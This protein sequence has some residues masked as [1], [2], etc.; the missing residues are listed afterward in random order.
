MKLYWSTRSPFARKVT[1]AAHEL[2]LAARIDLVPIVV[3]M[4]APN[5]EVMAANPLSKIPTLILDDGSALYDSLVIIE[6][7]DGLSGA[8]RLV[9]GE[10]QARLATLKRH[11]LGN[12]L[13]DLLVLWRNERDRPSPYGSPAHLA[14]YA[15]KADAALDALQRDADA[16]ASTPFD[17][18][19]I[20]VGC[21]LSYL[22][23]RFPTLDWRAGRPRLAAWHSTFAARDSARAT[24]HRDG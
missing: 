22:D 9:P 21:A 13:L 12:G 3:G 7:L 5:A 23:F 17:V 11:A 4:S 10:R 1:V 24:E 2:G 19:H 20:A 16:I 8:P 18:A 6:Y 15:V 14:A